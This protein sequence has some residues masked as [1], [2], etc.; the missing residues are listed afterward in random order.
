MKI[1]LSQDKLRD[2]AQRLKTYFENKNVTRNGKPIGVNFCQQI[3]TV[4]LLD[5]PFEAVSALLD[6]PSP[7]PAIDTTADVL[8]LHYE[9]ETVIAYRTYYDH[10]ALNYFTCRSVG[11]DMEV[12]VD[13]IH[14]QAQALA[15]T[16]NTNV[17]DIELPT[18]LRDDWEYDDIISLATAMGYHKPSQ[19][20]LDALAN[21][22]KK[23]FIDGHH[24]DYGLSDEWFRELPDVAESL[25]DEGEP[26]LNDILAAVMAWMP[27]YTNDDLALYEYFFSVYDLINATPVPDCD[28]TWLVEQKVSNDH[29]FSVRVSLH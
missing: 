22:D 4:G 18:I 1:T 29:T 11:T 12:S 24:V 7:T 6:A 26:T 14:R 2:G 25:Y 15:G 10:D 5:R 27:E 23:I 8:L 3:L 9:S 16:R 20:L 21:T 28:N 13:E 17:A 19:T